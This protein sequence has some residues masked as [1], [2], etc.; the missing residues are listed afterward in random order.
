MTAER[1]DEVQALVT[2][3][4]A[5]SKMGPNEQAVGDAALALSRSWRGD[6]AEATRLARDA[7]RLTP[8]ATQSPDDAV[9]ATY[10]LARVLHAAGETEE[11]RL[12]AI[13]ASAIAAGK[14]LRPWQ[15]LADDL[16][17]SCSG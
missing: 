10:T 1:A 13:E 5:A 6:H 15:R 3:G 2:T 7:V 16:A 14:G 11:A 9:K 4:R 17:A 8:D 12:V